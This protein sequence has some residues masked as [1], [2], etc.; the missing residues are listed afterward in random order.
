MLGL[1]ALAVYIV[2]YDVFAMRRKRETLSS[3]FHR[4]QATKKG[5]VGCQ[6]LCVV[7][8][9]HLLRPRPRSRRGA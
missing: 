4:L 5:K 8:S 7:G 3:A 1:V 9:V 6:L 2:G